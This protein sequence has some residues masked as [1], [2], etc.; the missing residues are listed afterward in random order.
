MT[1]SSQPLLRT[2]LA[3]LSLTAAGA[4]S[5]AIKWKEILRQPAP[6]YATP[7]A[8]AIA[9]T[10]LLYQTPSGGWPKNR[11]MTLPPAEE[12]AARPVGP[13]EDERVATIDND[14]TYTQ[15]RFLAHVQARQP[16][17]RYADAISRGIDYLLAAQYPNGGWP[18]FYPLRPGYYTHITFNDD[19]MTGVLELL[20]DIARGEPD[21]AWVDSVRRR[22]AAAAV[23]RGL[24]C[25]LRCQV[26]VQG[27]KTVWCAQHD[28][29]TLAPAPAR[30]YE[31]VSL[32]GYE[33]VG[34]VRFLMGESHP[35]PAVIA[36]VEA[37][38]A[39]F[40]R[41][42]ITGLR[43]ERVPDP[44]LRHGADRRVVA[45]PTAP[46]L[47]ARFYEIGTDRP[48]FTGR[49]AVIRYSMAEIEAERRG[50]YNYY[51]EAPNP[52]LGTDYPRWAARLRRAAPP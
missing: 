35:S 50:G 52:L 20:R 15:I 44:S 7:A 26:V 31:P 37:A 32:S 19:A 40:E 48:V 16:A 36:A 18:Q 6:W 17:P 33:S 23:A 34:V 2:L 24:D 13:A 25:I 51:T 49:D 12:I 10:V 30:R 21:F 11:E 38:I 39:W 28:E 1:H 8:G 43:V 41:T 5:A 14:A 9:D 45:D 27:V 29:Q 46:P 22:S 47:W 42:R 4:A 3:L